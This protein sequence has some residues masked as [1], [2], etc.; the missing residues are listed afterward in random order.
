MS[1]PFNSETNQDYKKVK[2]KKCWFFN[3][4]YNANL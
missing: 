4:P 3:Y 1:F 2:Y